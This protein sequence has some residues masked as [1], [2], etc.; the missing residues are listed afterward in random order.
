MSAARYSNLSFLL[1]HIFSRVLIPFSAVIY[2]SLREVILSPQPGSFL[3][4]WITSAFTL[5]S[6]WGLHSEVLGT[7]HSHYRRRDLWALGLTWTLLA[8]IIQG[9]LFH[10]IYHVPLETVS[11]RYKI[12]KLEPWPYMLMGLLLTPRLSAIHVRHWPL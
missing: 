7:Y 4:S 11:H 12:F 2:T 8:I 5:I 3:D 10:L 9:T 6:F 1:Y